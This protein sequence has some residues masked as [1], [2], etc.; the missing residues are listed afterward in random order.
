MECTP[1][2][3][4][5]SQELTLC[6][7]VYHGPLPVSSAARTPTVA[8]IAILQYMGK[9]LDWQLL[10]PL[11]ASNNII[12][13]AVTLLAHTMLF[14][15]CIHANIAKPSAAFRYRTFHCTAPLL[16]QHA[17]THTCKSISFPCQC[18]MHWSDL[19][20]L[21][22]V[23]ICQE[24][25]AADSLTRGVP[26][27]S[28]AKPSVSGP[29]I[30]LKFF[31]KRKGSKPRSPADMQNRTKVGVKG[32]VPSMSQGR[33]LASSWPS[34]MVNFSPN[35]RGSKPRSPASCTI[36]I[37]NS[38]AAQMTGCSIGKKIIDA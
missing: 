14:M 36:T 3:N 38:T 25:K 33:P 27:T 15:H 29:L 6:T 1:W 9:G 35:L 28:H 17:H 22:S 20:Q 23:R 16:A 2:G 34:P 24:L 12:R 7:A 26:S 32:H 13:L 19:I 21:A 8:S 37:H 30:S 5:Q 31:P 10:Q 11:H 4:H 18:H